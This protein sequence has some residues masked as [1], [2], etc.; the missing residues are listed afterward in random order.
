VGVNFYAAP[1]EL[2]FEGFR[3]GLTVETGDD[4]SS[5]RDSAVGEIVDSPHRV[6]IVGNTEIGTHLPFLDIS[7]VDAHDDL[8]IILDHLQE[9]HFDIG[10]EA[11]QDTRCM[12]VVHDFAAELEIELVVEHFYTFKDRFGLFFQILFVVE[13][14]FKDHFSP[15]FDRNVATQK[16]LKNG[17]QYIEKNFFK[18]RKKSP[19]GKL[20]SSAL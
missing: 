12:V 10:I 6:G 11:R 4:N 7:G 16:K 15:I 20:F 14:D 2:V 9:A 19:F 17:I 1:F 3:S 18:A 13:T 5:H 8:G